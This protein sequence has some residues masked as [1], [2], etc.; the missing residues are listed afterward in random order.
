MGCCFI[1][2]MDNDPKQTAK[3]TQDF[4]KVKKWDILH[5]QIIHL[6]S[7]QWN[8][9]FT[10]Q[11]KIEGNKTHK[12]ATTYGSCSEDTAKHFK[13]EYSALGDNHSFRLQAVI[14]YKEFSSKY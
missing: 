5:C 14:D 4:L 8:M 6:I 7:T 13:G 3:T 11:D 9:L 10:Y 12:Q 2:Q 1:L